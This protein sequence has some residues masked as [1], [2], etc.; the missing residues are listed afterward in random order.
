MPYVILIIIIVGFVVFVI[1]RTEPY[2]KKPEGEGPYF[3]EEDAEVIITMF[4]SFTD[5]NCKAFAESG[6]MQEII[7]DYPGQVKFV[8]RSFSKD[9]VGQLAAEAALC[10]GDQGKFWEM[11]NSLFANQKSLTEDVLKYYSIPGL[12][13]NRYRNCMEVRKYRTDV[14]ADRN[15]GMKFKIDILP[16]FFIDGSR[17]EGNVGISEFKSLIDAELA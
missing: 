17:I 4:S 14:E 5:S 7:D 8:F 16:T 1:F 2:E 6:K 11:Y 3:G 10:A 9:E 15:Q 12:N 13:R